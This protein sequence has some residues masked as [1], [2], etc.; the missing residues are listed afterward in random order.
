LPK[1]SGYAGIPVADFVQ[2]TDEESALKALTDFGGKMLLKTRHGAF[3]GRG[4]AVVSNPTELREAYETFGGNDLYAERFVPFT[5]ELAVVLAKDIQGNVEVYPVVQTVHQRNICLEVLMPA[6]VK[7]TVADN[8]TQIALDI[9]QYLEGAGV[10]AIEM[11]VVGDDEVIINEIAPRVHNSGHLTI[12]ACETSQ[13]EQHV[14]A[15]TGMPLGSTLMKV[16]AAAMVN[17]LGE[18]DGPTEVK[19]LEDA[20]S[21]EGTTVHLYGKSPTKVDRKMGH[22]TSVGDTVEEARGR[23]QKARKLISI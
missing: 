8:A 14:R 5:D 4:N 18:R 21:V 3:D 12:E 10:F 2:I 6:P 23:A 19:G 17:I 22:V 9:A 20:Q 15:I 7:P 1:K 13:F 16:P 11:F